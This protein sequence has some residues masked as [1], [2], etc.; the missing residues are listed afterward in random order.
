MKKLF[1]ALLMTFVAMATVS[2]QE[3]SQMPQNRQNEDF[4][5]EM[6]F[7]YGFC[8]VI[9]VLVSTPMSFGQPPHSID[10]A[11]LDQIFGRYTSNSIIVGVTTAE[12]NF[13]FKKW[14]T[15]S[16]GV[17]LSYKFSQI[18]SGKDGNSMVGMKM[19][20]M[21]SFIPQA[22]FTYLSRPTVK[23]YSAVGAGLHLSS[24]GVMPVVQVAPLGVMFGNKVFGFF[25]TG[26]GLSY[27]GIMGGIGFR[28]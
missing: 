19:E 2:A 8:P 21:G 3:S 15:L 1:I 7:G 4:K 16:L 17:N 27:I 5:Y 9:D 13:I 23:L 28:F 24:F 22:R 14:F 11:T 6:R 26:V 20:T 10:D 12:F 25:E 18:R